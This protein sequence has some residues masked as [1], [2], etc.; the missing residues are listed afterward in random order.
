MAIGKLLG[1]ATLLRGGTQLGYNLAKKRQEQGKATPMLDVISARQEAGKA[2]PIADKLQTTYQTGQNRQTVTGNYSACYTDCIN[3]GGLPAEC[4]TQCYKSEPQT[5]TAEGGLGPGGVLT[6]E[7]EDCIYNRGG[8]WV[9]NPQANRFRC[10]MPEQEKAPRDP[11]DIEG[12][13]T[14]PPPITPEQVAIPQDKTPIPYMQMGP[15]AGVLADMLNQ[16]AFSGQDLD[17]LLGSQ[18]E[19]RRG[20]I[21]AAYQ[22]LQEELQERLAR[23]AQ[24][25]GMFHSGAAQGFREREMAKL[26]QQRMA[27]VERATADIRAQKPELLL[28]ERKQSAEIANMWGQMDQNMQAQ[29]LDGFL[30]GRLMEYNRM[31]ELGALNIDAFNGNANMM[32]MYMTYAVNSARTN[33]ELN[34]LRAQMDEIYAG[35]T[36]TQKNQ[37]LSFITTWMGS[38][39]QNIGRG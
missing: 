34:M 25:A 4:A 11:R 10:A 16:P 20:D 9:W 12:A 32:G 35:L 23:D 39:G 7:A 18:I 21:E 6:T 17:E 27:D 26:G 38:H 13:P 8:Q 30:N 31:A 19:A 15:Y 28:A 1:G 2:T 29:N 5:G 14:P 22:P 36:E 33:G 3:K 37:F 24:G